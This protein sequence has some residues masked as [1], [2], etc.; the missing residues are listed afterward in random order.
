LDLTTKLE[1][2]FEALK[3]RKPTESPKTT[4]S[5]PAKK[6]K[7]AK[8]VKAKK[9]KKKKKVE[10][11][12]EEKD[13][14]KEKVSE[15]IA[16]ERCNEVLRNLVRIEDQ[17]ATDYSNP[18]SSYILSY[19]LRVNKCGGKCGTPIDNLKRFHYCQLCVKKLMNPEEEDDE[20]LWFCG[21]CHDKAFHQV[22]CGE[23]Q[24]V[25]TSGRVRKPKKMD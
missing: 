16:C 23:G 15:L 22:S 14:P 5:R 25:R 8:N 12:E 10:E 9:I 2:Q 13:V 1:I 11:A 24:K 7:K 21:P 19:A 20:V 3:K 4:S 6:T 17:Y 18:K